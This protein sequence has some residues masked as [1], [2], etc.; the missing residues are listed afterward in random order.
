[1]IWATGVALLVPIYP[2]WSGRITSLIE[3]FESAGFLIAPVIGS[4][5]YSVGGYA[6]PFAFTAS[7]EFILAIIC[8][9]FVPN[10]FVENI[11]GSQLLNNNSA[12]NVEASNTRTEEINEDPGYTF[13]YFSTNRTVLLVSLPIICH[14][15]NFGFIDVA[16]MKTFLFFLKKNCD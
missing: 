10:N 12:I 7:C 9:F 2:E 4:Y 6:L 16:G 11:Y 8:I 1:M 14:S 15:L 3:T 13:V 5:M